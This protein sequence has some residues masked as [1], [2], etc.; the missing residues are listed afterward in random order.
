MTLFKK[1]LTIKEIITAYLPPF[2]WAFIIFL[3]SS[4]SSLP[5]FEQSVFD[6][7]L[8]KSAHIFVYLVLYFLVFKAANTTI[9]KQHTKIVLIL[10]I[11]ICFTYAVSDELH[12]SFVP[13]RFATFRDIGFDML[14]V[15]IGFLKKYDYI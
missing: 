12:Q 15:G 10:P 1:D 7:L 11:L 6:F 2:L 8:K 14:G 13:G 5:G 4:Q 3:F 9:K